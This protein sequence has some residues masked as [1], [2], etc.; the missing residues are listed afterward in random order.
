MG[1]PV[2]PPVVTPIVVETPLG[3]MEWSFEIPEGL[4]ELQDA[5]T[6][7]EG[8]IALSPNHP[9]VRALVGG[10]DWVFVQLPVPEPVATAVHDGMIYVVGNF[11]ITPEGF[12][13]DC[14]TVCICLH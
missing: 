10:E 13:P 5:I 6:Q 2:V 1:A 11:T 8:S 7:R 4:T 3:M 14:I 9:A 12:C